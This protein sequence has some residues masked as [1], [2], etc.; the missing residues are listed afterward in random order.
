M[1]ATT[2]RMT[3]TSPRSARSRF[4]AC[5]RAQRRAPRLRNARP[6]KR[7]AGQKTASRIFFR[8]APKTRQENVTQT[9]G[10]HQENWFCGYDF[11][12]GY[13]V[14]PNSV[15]GLS[16]EAIEIFTRLDT[17]GDGFINILD[18]VQEGRGILGMP[19]DQR[20][21][22][23]E[24][25][26]DLIRLIEEFGFTSSN[27]GFVLDHLSSPNYIPDD[28]MVSHAS[29]GSVIVVTATGAYVLQQGMKLVR[30]GRLGSADVR[31]LNSAIAGKLERAGW[32]IV[33]GGGRDKEAYLPGAGPGTKGGNYSD[34]MATKNGQVLHVNTISTRADG[35]T[36]TKGEARAATM[37]RI[38]LGP[39]ERL[40]LIPK[41]TKQI[42]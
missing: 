7:V 5:S 42:R 9:L 25:H 31:D 19:D 3:T 37:I 20:F 34:I 13:T 30:G 10:T 12:L 24:N 1:L 22:V 23:S 41:G 14:A 40:I 2:Q 28:S 11:A 35:V 39:N 17:N 15:G 6:A 38:K 8:T 33:R 16:H 29:A 18:E 21:R 4:F 27:I 26:K 36:P 32:T